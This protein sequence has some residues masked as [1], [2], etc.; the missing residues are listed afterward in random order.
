M[1]IKM[2]PIFHLASLLGLVV[3]LSLPCD[4][5]DF[6]DFVILEKKKMDSTDEKFVSKIFKND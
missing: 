6:I 3:F 2:K 1:K 5:V 4:F